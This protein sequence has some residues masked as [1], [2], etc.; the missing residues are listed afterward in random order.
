MMP[1]D[2]SGHIKIKVDLEIADND[3][4]SHRCC[5]YINSELGM[6]E[7]FGKALKNLLMGKKGNVISLC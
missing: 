7:R 2:M 4:R 1:A 6:L 3:A 5:F